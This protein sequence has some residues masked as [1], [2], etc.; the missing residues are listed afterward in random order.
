M[1]TETTT[2]KNTKR[3]LACEREF[4]AQFARIEEWEE[5]INL[6]YYT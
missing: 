1:N 2:F 3:V 4:V 5:S 6:M